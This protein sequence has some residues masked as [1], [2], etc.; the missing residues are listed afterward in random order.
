MHTIIFDYLIEPDDEFEDYTNQNEVWLYFLSLASKKLNAICTKYHQQHGSGKANI[1]GDGL[2]TYFAF[3]GHLSCLQ[4]VHEHGCEWNEDACVYAAT[5]GHL[6]CLKY[7][8]ENG[9]DWDE[10][11]CTSAAASGSLDCL[12]YAHENGCNWMQTLGLVRPPMVI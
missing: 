5:N 8:H 7:V 1:I 3:Y 9:G 6:E 10:D 12:Q 2:T 4:F 11:T